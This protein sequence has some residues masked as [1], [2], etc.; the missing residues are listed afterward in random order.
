MEVRTGNVSRWPPATG[1]MAARVRDHDW[2]GSP[3]GPSTAW[4]VRLRAA[5]ETMLASGLPGGVLWGP[6]FVQIYNDAARPIVELQDPAALGRPARESWAPL[7]SVAGPVLDRVM[8]TG[9]PVV[10]AELRL[11]VGPAGPA[12]ATI[13]CS[14]LHGEAGEVA[15][16]LVTAALA[17]PIRPGL[18]GSDLADLQAQVRERTAESKANRDLLQAT[19][20]AST[21]MIQV[22]EAIRDAA[23][24]IVDFRWVLNNHTSETRYGEVQGQSLLERNP[25]VIEEGIFDVFKRVTETGAP[26]QAERHYAHEQFDGWFYQSVVKLGDGVAT[27]TKDISAWKA[28]Q[29]EV[30]RLQEAVAQARL[31]ESEERFRKLIEASAQAVWETDGDGRVFEDSPSWRAYTGQS[32]EDWFAG[33]WLDAVHPA[34]RG[35]AEAAWRDAL[36]SHRPVDVE[37]RLAHNGGW[38]WTNVRAAPL[39][40]DDGAVRK[41]IGMN[42]DITARKEA[43]ERM[44]ESEER[45]Q[46]AVEVGRLGLWDWNI[47]TGDVHWSD[48][49]FRM[50]GYR[51]GEVTPSY[52][53]WAARIHPDDRPVAEAALRAAMEARSDYV[54]EFRVVHP[55]G[56][57]HWLSGRGRFFYGE[58][59]EPVRMIGAMVDTTEQREWDE[60]QRILVAELQHRTRNLMSIVR[61]IAENTIRSSGDMTDFRK[62][63]RDRLEAL[64]RVQ[65]LLSRLDEHDRV[66]FG[67]LIRSEL[68]AMDGVSERVTLEGP[69]GVRLRSS[70]VQILA[71]ALHELATNAIKHGALGTPDGRLHVNWSLVCDDGSAQPWLSVDWRERGVELAPGTPV[72]PRAG[73][74]R[75]LIERALPYQLGARTSYEWAGDGVH[76][77]ICFPVSSRRLDASGPRSGPNG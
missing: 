43:E 74:G 16:V 50:E 65:S 19:M 49:H 13:C 22:F 18:P 21:D 42:I 69:A 51:V 73:Q 46:S 47:V 56:S 41:W 70:T 12:K 6:D 5:I 2:R 17:P 62:R 72:F 71:L 15:G 1:D 39:Y 40:A 7:W 34:D 64:A 38:R 35:L 10:D 52:A 31:R 23:G 45:L 68:A 66:S 63:F 54:Q 77:V 75:E 36:G 48:E 26:E 33:G 9:A 58:G 30:L 76:C 32:A 37:F 20:D 60:R 59:G 11:P 55:D 8:R 44:R 14:A 67:D 57:I 4:P 3:L 53:A 29:D 27:T 24:E 28:S 25:G 61:S